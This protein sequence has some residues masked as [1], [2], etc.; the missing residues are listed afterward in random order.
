MTAGTLVR[1]LAGH[2]RGRLYIVLRTE[3]DFAYVA[4]GKY[5]SLSDPKKKRLKH[6]ADEG[7][8]ID[9]SSLEC[10]AHVRKAIKRI[11]SEGG[12]HLG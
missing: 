9:V 6:I 12:C 1:S 11:K 10:D 8:E 7:A 3:N 4:D 5:H 2:D